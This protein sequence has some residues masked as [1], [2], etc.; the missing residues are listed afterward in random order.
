[1][2][3]SISPKVGCTGPYKRVLYFFL[4]LCWNY[5]AINNRVINMLSEDYIIN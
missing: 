2:Y 3:V 1:M 4:I 5:A